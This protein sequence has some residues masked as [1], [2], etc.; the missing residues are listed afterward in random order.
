MMR[1]YF[2][3]HECGQITVDET[4]VNHNN[5]GSVRLSAT[6]AARDIMAAEVRDGRLCLSCHIEVFDSAGFQVLKLPFKDVLNVS[7]L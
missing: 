3:L 7:G 2:N 1:Y 5:M 6:K 4:G